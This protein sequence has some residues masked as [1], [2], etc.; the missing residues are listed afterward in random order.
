VFLF[1]LSWIEFSALFGVLGG[2]TFALYL[3]TRM[4]M[5]LGKSGVRQ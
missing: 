3:L 4:V 1:N 5:E 2:A